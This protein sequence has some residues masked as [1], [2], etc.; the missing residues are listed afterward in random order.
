LNVVLFAGHNTFRKGIMGNV[1]KKID[2]N[3][4]DIMKKLFYEGLEAGIH[5]LS[6][7]LYYVPGCYSDN[8]PTLG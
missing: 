6:S 8:Q 5:G 1:N 7:G 3:E 4:K 2:D